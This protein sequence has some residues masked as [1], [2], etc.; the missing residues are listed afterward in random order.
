MEKYKKNMKENKK[1]GF[2]IFDIFCTSTLL[3]HFVK[4][5]ILIG[6]EVQI[7]VQFRSQ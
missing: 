5:G 1:K 6:L 3:R 2:H 7:E 4:S